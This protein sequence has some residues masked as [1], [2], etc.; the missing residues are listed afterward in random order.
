MTHPGFTRNY[1]STLA[2]LAERGHRVHLAFDGPPQVGKPS[3]IDGL[4][5]RYASISHGPAPDRDDVWSPLAGAC[6]ATRNY[7]RYLHPRYRQATRLRERAL[8]WPL[9][10]L[11]EA[12]AVSPLGGQRGLRVID[13]LLRGVERIVPS[14]RQIERFI[15]AQQPDGVLL[16]PLVDF[17]TPQLDQLKAARA[18]GVPVGVCVASWDNLTNKGLIQIEPDLVTVWNE[19]QKREAVELHAIPP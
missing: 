12:L 2:L 11:L 17:N 13:A 15:L 16:T 8:V 4:E 9:S 7:L 3:A 10:P 1:E 5:A 6:R 18:L 19:A 14:S